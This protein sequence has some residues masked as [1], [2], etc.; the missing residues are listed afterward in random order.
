MDDM[1][2]KEENISS[3]NEN[4]SDRNQDE[5]STIV[6]KRSVS[7]KTE[8]LNKSPLGSAV[9]VHQAAQQLEH[10]QLH[11]ARHQAARVPLQVLKMQCKL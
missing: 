10:Q 2:D 7:F 6:H 9:T 5:F 8:E 11:V 3:L 4:D 1:V